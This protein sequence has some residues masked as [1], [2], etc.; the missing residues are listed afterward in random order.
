M[1]ISN[2][3]E[4]DHS[5]SLPSGINAEGVE[6]IPMNIRK[7]HRSDIMTEVLDT[8]AVI[9]GSPTLNNCVIQTWM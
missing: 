5:G 7:W 4:P 3:A 9:I 8:G 1:V 2:H 6:A